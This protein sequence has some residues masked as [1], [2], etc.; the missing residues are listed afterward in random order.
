MSVREY[1]QSYEKSRGALKDTMTVSKQQKTDVSTT[2][3]I[4]YRK[5]NDPATAT[6]L[7]LLSFFDNQDIW[8]ELIHY[9]AKSPTA[10]S[11]LSQVA[12]KKSEFS[13]AMQLLTNLSLVEASQASGAYSLHSC[14]QD[15]CKGFCESQQDTEIGHGDLVGVFLTSVCSA[16]LELF[17]EES[18]WALR[19]RLLPHM[20]RMF[21]ILKNISNIPPDLSVIR[22]IKDVGSLYLGQGKPKQAEIMIQQALAGYEK[23]LGPKN[24]ETLLVVNYL[25][26]LYW[27]RKQP[28][29][30]EAMFQRSLTGF[31][32]ALIPTHT[33]ILETRRRLGVVYRDK[34]MLGK[35]EDM[36]RQALE[37]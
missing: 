3:L 37:G 26:Y 15:W 34:G 30:S 36:F 28:D 17:K 22:A 10:P 9:A 14:V 13:K 2:L 27:T 35:A 18:S 19:Q 16:T 21:I 31:N 33:Y 29:L 11:W 4:A 32:E 6:F 23:T 5:I 24:I 20:N 8:F 12:S 7:L 1:S 25:G